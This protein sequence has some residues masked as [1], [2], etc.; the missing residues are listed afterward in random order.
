MIGG[1]ATIVVSSLLIY[2]IR[3]VRNAL[4]KAFFYCVILKKKTTF[5]L[6]WIIETI[7]QTCGTFLMFLV[8]IASPE[9]ISALK[10]NKADIIQEPFLNYSTYEYS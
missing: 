9:S 1:F 7:I 6:P 4:K 3:S 5:I 10:V 2:G 8:N